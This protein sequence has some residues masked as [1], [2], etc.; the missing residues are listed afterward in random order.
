MFDNF[1]I[2]ISNLFKKAEKERMDLHHPYVG[3]EHLLLAIL[4][5]N[6]ECLK[7]LNKYNITYESFFSDFL[8]F[9]LENSYL[10]RRKWY[11]CRAKT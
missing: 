7:I 1:G 6:D 2:N 9:S 4:K 11:I 8:I 3:T 5:S 10:F